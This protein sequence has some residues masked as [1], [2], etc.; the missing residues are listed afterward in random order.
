MGGWVRCE[1]G[2][3]KEEIGAGEQA[4]ERLNERESEREPES[5]CASERV[6]RARA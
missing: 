5:E 4:E 2:A 1:G 6:E 3:R